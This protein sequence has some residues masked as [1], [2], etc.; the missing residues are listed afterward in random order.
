METVPH[1]LQALSCRV[2]TRYNNDKTSTGFYVFGYSPQINCFVKPNRDSNRNFFNSLYYNHRA[3]NDFIIMMW[4]SYISMDQWSRLI[5]I[6]TTSLVI[7]IFIFLR[8]KIFDSTSQVHELKSWIDHNDT[9]ILEYFLVLD[10]S[11]NLFMIIWTPHSL[12][13]VC[14]L[15]IEAL[16]RRR[17]WLTNFANLYPIIAHTLIYS[18]KRLYKAT[19]I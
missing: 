15:T 13:S 16:C 8:P 9:M 14:H 4:T 1:Y 3:R 7:D 6:V 19:L 5:K 17:Y 10:W 18:E 11:N 2:S 12:E